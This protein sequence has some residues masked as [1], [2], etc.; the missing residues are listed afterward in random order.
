VIPLI[1]MAVAGSDT[2]FDHLLIWL[3]VVGLA[4]S[5]L[6]KTA[7]E[8]WPVLVRWSNEKRSRNW[9][10][11]PG[12]IDIVA[13]AKEVESAGKSGVVITYKALLTYSYHNPDLQTGDYDRSFGVEDDARDWVDSL[14]GC[15]VPVYVDPRDPRLSVLRSE[16]VEAA[17]LE[18]A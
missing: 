15:K 6:F 1:A 4:L 17:C 5:A 11:V 13:V 8:L 3:I 7:T 16:D 14:K 9:P 10:S 18:K 12:V 2:G